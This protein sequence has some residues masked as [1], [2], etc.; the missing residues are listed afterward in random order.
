MPVSRT[1]NSTMQP[2]GCAPTVIRRPRGVYLMA[3]S[4]RL[5]RICETASLSQ[6]TTVSSGARLHQPIRL[7]SA[8]GRIISKAS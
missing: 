5:L 3:L 4:I 2:G 7:F 1:K 6:H 8:I